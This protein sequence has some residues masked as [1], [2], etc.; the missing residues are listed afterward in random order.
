[1]SAQHSF[2]QTKPKVFCIGLGKTGTTSIGDALQLLGAKRLTWGRPL[3]AKLMRAVAHHDFQSLFDT[4][5]QHDALED[6]PWPLVYRELDEHFPHAKFILTVRK[7]PAAW[8][9]ALTWQTVGKSRRRLAAYKQIY[10]H[11]Y[12]HENAQAFLDR[13]T[14]HN[15]QVTRYFTE[16][17]PAGGKLLELCFERG[18]GWSELCPFLGLPAPDVPFPH[19]NRRRRR[20]YKDIYLNTFMRKR[21]ELLPNSSRR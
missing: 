17:Y 11:H 9:S 7:D 10:G 19:S 18:D 4:A 5:Y 8:L 20:W 14:S 2:Q 6:F 13:Y 21:R 15:E 16:K 3:S 12:P 1:L